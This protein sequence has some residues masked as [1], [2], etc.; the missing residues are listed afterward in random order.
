L[1]INYSFFRLLQVPVKYTEDGEKVIPSA[2]TSLAEQPRVSPSR[3]QA[4]TTPTGAAG[5]AVGA[6]AAGVA[7]AGVNEAAN[8]AAAAANAS[9]ISAEEARVGEE[10]DDE[11]D[12]TPPP[13]AN[14]MAD[15]MSADILAKPFN[16]V[17][18]N[19]RKSRFNPFRKKSG[20]LN[21]LAKQ[22]T[23]NRLVGKNG[24]I[25]TQSAM[26]GITHHFFKDFFITILD[27]KW[28]WIFVLFAAGFTSSWGLFAV[29]W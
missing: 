23:R 25:N 13:V 10:E 28:S 5:A 6:A 14:S 16:F 26:D 7:V 22:A 20:L 9:V 27:L 1:L 12:E 3:E 17:S 11:D 21:V 8:V 18:G 4:P 24:T 19:V 15:F 2:R 29:A